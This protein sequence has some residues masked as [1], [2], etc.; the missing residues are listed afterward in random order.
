MSRYIS[1]INSAQHSAF[2]GFIINKG[3]V[4]FSA[5]L[6]TNEDGFISSRELCNAL[7]TFDIKCNRRRRSPSDGRSR[8]K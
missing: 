5:A 1:F 8:R 4:N 3:S 7:N 6:V 2:D